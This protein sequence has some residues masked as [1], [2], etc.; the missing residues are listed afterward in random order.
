MGK[1]V[2]LIWDRMGDYHRAR[3]KAVQDIF[4]DRLVFAADLGTSDDLYR[5]MSTEPDKLFFVLSRKPTNVVDIKRVLVFCRILS[6]A[7]I[8]TVCIPGYGRLEYLLFLFYSWL[9]HRKVILFAESWYPSRF[10]LDQ[11]KSIFLKIT[12]TGFLVSGKRA[13][14]HFINALKIHRIRI[15]T[16]YSVV[17]NDHFKSHGITNHKSGPKRLLC[18]AR[19]GTEK[20]LGLLIDAFKNSDLS[21]HGWQLCIVGDGPLKSQLIDQIGDSNSHVTLLDWQAYELLPAIYAAS[22]V[23]ILPSKFEPW[24]LVVNEAM[25]A[26]LPVILSDAVGSA[27]DLLKV[28]VNGWMFQADKLHELVEILNELCITSPN[29]LESMGAESQR[30]IENYSLT[31]FARNLKVLVEGTQREL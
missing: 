30:I 7:N 27:P 20:N 3:W 6:K 4:D 17:D 9:T 19:F 15:G 29:R 12:C 13:A 23:F 26:G 14:L 31:T 8:S 18:V 22:N 11:I 1:N 10:P 21:K 28:N 25:A 2:L 5:W 16:C 24:G